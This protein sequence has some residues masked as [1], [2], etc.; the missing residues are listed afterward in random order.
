MAPPAVSVN[1]EGK[2]LES[3]RLSC[4]S[5]DRDVAQVRMRG[6]AAAAQRRFFTFMH[7]MGGGVRLQ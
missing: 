5:L 7:R 2:S 4:T 3:L 1:E 6:A